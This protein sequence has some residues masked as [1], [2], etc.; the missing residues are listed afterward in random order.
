MR[1]GRWTTVT[2]S[3]FEHERE[4][5]EHIR[6]L[7]PDSEPY[8]AWSNF[9]FTA[10]T[11]H[12]YE[13]DLLVVTPGGMYLIE[14]KSLHGRLWNS[15]ST[16]ML[17]N[18]SIRTFDNPLHLADSKAKRLRSLLTAQVRRSG[19]NERIPEFVSVA[20]I[21]APGTDLA[22]VV[23]DLVE[24]EHVP[25]L[26]ALRYKDSGLAKRADWEHVWDLQRQ[27]DAAEDEEAKAKIRKA[28]PVPP[29]YGQADFRKQSFWSNRGK[30]DVPKERFISYPLAGRD[31]DSS[32]LI[33]WAGWDHLDQAHVLSMLV[34]QRGDHDGWPA[35]RLTPLLAGLR[36]VLPWARQW[37][38]EVEPEAVDEF[39]GL[40]VE[41][42]ARLHLT[43]DDLTDWRP[44][45]ATRG[46]RV[47]RA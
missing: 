46:R 16:W 40:L 30:L 41:R 28:I 36:E 20:E 21:Y 26:A 1:E 3:Q 4:A 47:A 13:V 44:P 2:P 25:Y 34:V 5:L 33:G 10:E 45:A 6:S 35:E 11:G 42:L 38:Y 15:G 9:T 23:A 7:L 14:V 19:G 32:L 29:K 37:H 43:V 24:T 8:R 27:E 18:A 22:K 17:D 31:G 12:V 39:E